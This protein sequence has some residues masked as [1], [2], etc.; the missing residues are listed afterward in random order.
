MAKNGFVTKN[1]INFFKFSKIRCFYG[2]CGATAISQ[3]GN[4]TLRGMIAG[5]K[6]YFKGLKLLAKN[7]KKRS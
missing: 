7:I 2:D 6:K 1:I 3:Q 4:D 5:D